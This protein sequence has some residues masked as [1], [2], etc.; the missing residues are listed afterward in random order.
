[1][2]KD[3]DNDTKISI[4]QFYNTLN[5]YL[6]KKTCKTYNIAEFFGVTGETFFTVTCRFFSK[7][8]C[9]KIAL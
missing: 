9:H 1:M 4:S 6:G 7:F 3:F 5:S 8:F 2:T